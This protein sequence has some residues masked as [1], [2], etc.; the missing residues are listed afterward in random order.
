MNFST[1]LACE[2]IS[3]LPN[4]HEDNYDHWRFGPQQKEKPRK[5]LKFQIKTYLITKRGFS[6]LNYKSIAKSINLNDLLISSFEY[7]YNYLHD[8]SSQKLL[9]KVLAFRILGHS[10]VKLP[11][12]TEAFWR[13][14][15]DLEKIGDWNDTLSLAY[16]NVKLCRCKLHKIGI[17]IDM[18][19]LP[20]GI[21]IDF[22]QKQY[23]YASS[24]VIVG[25]CEGDTVIDA[26]GCWGDTALFFA[27][28]VGEGG[29]VY[30][31]E[32]IP[33][34]LKILKKNI[35]MNPA[36]EKIVNIVDRPVWSQSDKMLFYSDNGPGSSVSFEATGDA[37]NQVATLTIDDLVK[38]DNILKVDF[39]KM[40]IEGAELP[41]LKGAEQTIRQHLPK[42]AI[43]IY[44]RPEDFRVIPEYI[45]SLNL[46]YKFYFGHSSIH[47]EESV[48]FAIADK[49]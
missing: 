34:N 36:L 28:T 11:T 44:H 4:N 24:D 43:S 46:G 49:I 25:A 16:N 23:E 45:V 35:A 32:F 26:G 21:Y 8:E 31:F 33:S 14:A 3:N 40:D 19:Y 30:V 39:I 22:I 47:A 18:Y 6:H 7:L 42:L 15:D 29:R 1:A 13:Y 9:V 10:F 5:D 41:A 20:L 38:R 37:S 12:N 17:P 2:L 48:L 27:N